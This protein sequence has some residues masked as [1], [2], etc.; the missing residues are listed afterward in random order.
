[1]D[2]PE[3]SDSSEAEKL[4]AGESEEIEES[5]ESS[6]ESADSGTDTKVF[7]CS[8]VPVMILY[9]TMCR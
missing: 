3:M 5:D 9:L 6:E 2:E 7:P 4:D 1:V 8:A